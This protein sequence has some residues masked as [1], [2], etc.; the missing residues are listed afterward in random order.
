M[1]KFPTSSHEEIQ[2]EKNPQKEGETSRHQQLAQMQQEYTEISK[3]PS[4]KEYIGI[5]DERMKAI[6]EDDLML[7][8]EPEVYKDILG[9]EITREENKEDLEEILERELN[10]F[11]KVK[12]DVE[13][14]REGLVH[15]HRLEYVSTWSPYV[16]AIL[17][18]EIESR[19]QLLNLRLASLEEII[20]YIEEKKTELLF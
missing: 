7:V 1:E 6:D 13:E 15:D 16:D 19:I 17:K 2:P 8:V 10:H 12:W 3:H 18:D 14:D 11:K 9:K 20:S 4:Y 5:L